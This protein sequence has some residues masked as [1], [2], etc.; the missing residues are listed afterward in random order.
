MTLFNQPTGLMFHHLHGVGHPP[1]QGSIDADAFL[2]ILEFVGLDKIISPEEWLFR[3]QSN[4][5]SKDHCCITFD[6]ALLCQYQ[7]AKPVLDRLNLKAFFFVYS[8]V[9]EGGIEKLEIYRHF[10]MSKFRDVDAF[11]EDFFVRVWQKF[12]DEYVEFKKNFDPKT[13]LPNSQFYTDNDRRF[14]FLRDIVLGK[15]RY[16]QTMDDMLDEFNYSAI[17][18]AKN[19]WLTSSQVKQLSDEGHEIGLH[20]YTHPTQLS[21]LSYEGQKTEYTKNHNHLKTLLGKPPVTMSHPCNSYTQDTLAI[22]SELGIQMGFRADIAEVPNRSSLEF[23]RE[24]HANI[25]A[26]L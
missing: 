7:I 15:D 20:S 22:L 16:E 9:L 18:E 14:R 19:L 25:L 6:D 3:A 2:A 17:K 1:G 21:K 23:A 24:D 10:R 5:L 4:T 12:E 11:Y 26:K 8:S 13:Y